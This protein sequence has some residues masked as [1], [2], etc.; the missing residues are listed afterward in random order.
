MNDIAVY[1]MLP[2][3]YKKE[4]KIDQIEEN[5]LSSSSSE[6]EFKTGFTFQ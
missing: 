4:R 6:D 3:N 5:I 1:K 2:D